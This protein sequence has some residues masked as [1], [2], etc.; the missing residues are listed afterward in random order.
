MNL[1]P[2]TRAHELAALTD[3]RRWLVEHLWSESAVGIVGG[4]PKCGKSFL[5]LD[6]A[7]AVASGTPCLRRFAVNRPGRVLLFAAEDALHV[8][9]ERLL[10]IC[11]AAG[12]RLEELDIHVITSPTLR[13]DLASDARRLADTVAALS[14]RLLVLDPFV[15]LHRIDENVSAAVAPLLASLREIQRTHGTA[16][17]LVHHARK[18]GGAGRPGQAL[19][20][21][22]ELHAWGDS[23]LYLRRR[24]DRVVLSVEH[25]AAPSIA[26]V[27]LRLRAEH[28]VLALE[29][30][31]ATAPI[32]EPPAATLHERVRRA[33]D[34]APAPLGLDDLRAA[35]RVRKTTLC[36]ALA[37]LARQR[38]IVRTD[39][40]YALAPLRR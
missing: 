28:D 6:L 25:R 39:E 33:L 20:G 38:I 8:V 2:V 34:D 24:G 12:V 3:E 18:G 22:S 37:D 13:L 31:G 7:V 26:D 23:N 32:E 16:V 36:A 21:S 5:A 15:R 35:C 4:E 14:P 1:L 30:A 40:G 11:R 17:V 19:R 10:G 27:A 9:R 29:I